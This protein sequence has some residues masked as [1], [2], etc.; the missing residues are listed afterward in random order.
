MG[1]SLM[2][3]AQASLFAYLNGYT[4]LYYAYGAQWATPDC[5]EML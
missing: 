1:L 4:F 2:I 3:G 5:L